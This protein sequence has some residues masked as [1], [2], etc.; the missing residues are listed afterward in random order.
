MGP[1]FQEKSD[2]YISRSVKSI[3]IGRC[4]HS[5][6]PIFMYLADILSSPTHAIANKW[7]GLN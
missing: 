3:S 5:P 6:G 4:E 2:D 7:Q 1:T